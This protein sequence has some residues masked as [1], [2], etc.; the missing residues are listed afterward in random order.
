MVS[1]LLNDSFDV[2]VIS[3]RYLEDEQKKWRARR[4]RIEDDP[5]QLQT[6][7]VAVAAKLKKIIAISKRNLDVLDDKIAAAVSEAFPNGDVSSL[8]AEVELPENGGTIQFSQEI[9][10]T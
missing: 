6:Q 7:S 3:K 10:G 2:L 5:E 4:P 8:E 9:D 1:K